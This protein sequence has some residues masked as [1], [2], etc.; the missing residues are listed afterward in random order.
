[1]QAQADEW[2]QHPS[3]R[4]N[5]VVPGPVASPARAFTHPGVSPATLPAVESILPAYLWLIGPAS[6]GTSG[7]IVDCQG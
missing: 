5:A 7:R 2:A 3:L 1:M 6:R 4:V